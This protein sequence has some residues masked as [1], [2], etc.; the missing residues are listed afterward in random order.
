[1]RGCGVFA[2]GYNP[3]PYCVSVERNAILGVAGR[4]SRVARLPVRRFAAL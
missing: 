1:M 2:V 3:I 4:G